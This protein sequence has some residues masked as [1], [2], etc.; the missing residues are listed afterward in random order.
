MPQFLL[1]IK[2]TLENIGKLEPVEFNAWKFDIESEGGEPRLGITVSKT[3]DFEL[4]GGKGT[5]NFIVKFPG[6]NKQ[7]YIKLV[8]IKKCDGSYKAENSDSYVTVLGLEC[9]G[10]IITRWYP[11]GW[12]TCY[13]D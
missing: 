8:E 3:D 5:A 6:E 7:S 12:C 2:C 13:Y 10:L 9:R 1:K 11:S 4:E